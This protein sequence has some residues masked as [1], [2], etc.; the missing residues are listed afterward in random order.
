MLRLKLA[1]FTWGVLRR[2][3]HIE[4]SKIAH[5]CVSSSRFQINVNFGAQKSVELLPIFFDQT[6]NV[7]FQPS[8]YLSHQIG[9]EGPGSILSFLKK[10]GWATSL[11]ASGSGNGAPGFEFLR[12]SVHMTALGLSKR[13]FFPAYNATP[14][15]PGLSEHHD[16]ILQTIFS[17][18]DLIRSEILPEWAFRENVALGEIGWKW[19]EH[20]LPEPTVTSLSSQLQSLY[21]RTK[22][23]VGPYFPTEFSPELVKTLVDNLTPDRCRILVGSKDPLPG[24]EWNLTEK[25]Y[26]TEYCLRALDLPALPNVSLKLISEETMPLSNASFNSPTRR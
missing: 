22:L 25:Y 11:S 3:S 16:E 2:W 1:N 4:Q 17:Y 5:S 7:L 9:H 8:R 26:S 15:A 6:A 19:K 20:S 14:D 23:L 21:S 24:C 10:K 18:I 13:P 12:V